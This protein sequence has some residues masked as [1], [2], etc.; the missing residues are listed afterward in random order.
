MNGKQIMDLIE[1]FT[2]FPDYDMIDV[3]PPIDREPPFIDGSFDLDV[4]VDNN[5]KTFCLWIAGD[6]S[7][8]INLA[9]T[10]ENAKLIQAAVKE[11]GYSLIHTWGMQYTSEV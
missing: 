2:V 10:V 8:K 4:D 1:P 6:R 3:W 9:V 5:G 11:L 7:V